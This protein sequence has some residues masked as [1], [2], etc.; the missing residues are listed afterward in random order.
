MKPI[1]LLLVFLMTACSH[2]VDEQIEAT[3][4]C[5]SAGMGVEFRKDL[6]GRVIQINCIPPSLGDR[7]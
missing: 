2:D 5:R 7:W 6:S 3:D 1:I 4:T